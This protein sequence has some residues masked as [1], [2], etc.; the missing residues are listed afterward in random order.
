LAIANNYSSYEKVTE[1]REFVTH[2]GEHRR[3][4]C[5]RYFYGHML[6]FCGDCSGR[7]CELRR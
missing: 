7:A 5:L 2:K 6:P 1:Q 4:D 3:A